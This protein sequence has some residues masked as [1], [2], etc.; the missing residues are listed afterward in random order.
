MFAI[1][2]FIPSKKAQVGVE[3]CWETYGACLNSFHPKDKRFIRRFGPIKDRID[4]HKVSV[5]FNKI[6]LVW[7]GFMAYQPLLVDGDQKAPFS[8]ATTLRCSGG[9]YSFS[10]LLH[11]TINTYLILLSK[12]VSSTIF[13]VLGMTQPGIE[14]RSPGPLANTLKSK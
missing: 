13:K 11:F 3:S 6:C 2:L 14:P 10:G 12:E 1:L 8:T 5:L 4:R 9:H 7:L